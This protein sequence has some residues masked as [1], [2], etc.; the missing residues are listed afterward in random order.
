M[1]KEKLKKGKNSSNGDPITLETINN[2]N[3]IYNSFSKDFQKDLRLF[4]ILDDKA[5]K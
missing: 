2:M 5:K 1:S 3:H 4:M